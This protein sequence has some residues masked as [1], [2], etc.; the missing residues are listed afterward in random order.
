MFLRII[1]A[2]LLL[3][4]AVMLPGCKKSGTD[5]KSQETTVKS[6][7]ELKAEAAKDINETNMQSA[8]K[9]IETEIE[10]DSSAE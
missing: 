3:A 5:T 1:V 4:S 10:K 8:L 6:E 2:I 9:G 7:A